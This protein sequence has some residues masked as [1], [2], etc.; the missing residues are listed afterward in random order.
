MVRD[1]DTSGK[2]LSGIAYGLEKSC[3]EPF[4]YKPYKPLFRKGTSEIGRFNS[5]YILK[6]KPPVMYMVML[7]L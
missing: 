7:I 5:F 6:A 4:F 3:E 1:P 2:D